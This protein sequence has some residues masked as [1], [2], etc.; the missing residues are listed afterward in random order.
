MGSLKK[1]MEGRGHVTMLALSV[2]VWVSDTLMQ[3]V[4]TEVWQEHVTMLGR[5]AII[6]SLFLAGSVLCYD[7]I[8]KRSDDSSDI[9]NGEEREIYKEDIH[10]YNRRRSNV[11]LR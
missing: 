5:G 4:I 9:A 11:R 1:A 8:M 7:R 6:V 10:S 2:I 3:T